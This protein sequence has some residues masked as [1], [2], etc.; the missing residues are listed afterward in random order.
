MRTTLKTLAVGVTLLVV[1]AFAASQFDLLDMVNPFDSETVIRD[2]AAVLE[3][4]VERARSKLEYTTLATRFVGD[5]FT[6]SELY[7]VYRAVW[8]VDP[9]DKANFAR[10]VKGTEGF[11][12]P[13]DHTTPRRGRPARRRGSGLFDRHPSHQLGLLLLEVLELDLVVVEGLMQLGQLLHDP[14]R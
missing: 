9:G 2:H 7:D 1:G 6:I 3:S 11:A 8:G 4:A 14:L 10:K 13:T 12:V 5:R